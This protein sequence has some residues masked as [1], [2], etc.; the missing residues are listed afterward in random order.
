MKNQLSGAIRNLG[1][2]L[3][4]DTLGST[5]LYGEIGLYWCHHDGGNQLF[6]LNGDGE[7]SNRELCVDRQ[8]YIIKLAT[9]NDNRK[10]P[11]L[12]S[13]EIQLL[14]H[15]FLGLCMEASGSKLVLADC[16][17]SNWQKFMFN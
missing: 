16:T 6:R 5:P 10:G 7:L 2:G 17:G 12:Y 11:W 9:C 14:K 1:A 8:G 13:K 15:R 3:C 4:L